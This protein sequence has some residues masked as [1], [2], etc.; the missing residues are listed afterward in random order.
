MDLSTN[1]GNNLIVYI[2]KTRFPNIFQ[3]NQIN[4]VNKMLSSPIDKCEQQNRLTLACASTNWFSM[5]FFLQQKIRRS[6]IVCPIRSY[7][8][9]CQKIR[10]IIRWISEPITAT[11]S[12]MR[13]PNIWFVNIS[14]IINRLIA[15]HYPLSIFKYRGI[16]QALKVDL[17][18]PNVR[19]CCTQLISNYCEDD[20]SEDRNESQFNGDGRM[21]FIFLISN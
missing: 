3:S 17:F 12:A 7:N 6:S 21:V 8:H 14:S 18:S 15:H 2:L 11:T 13:W 5:T 19:H 4:H 1:R 9:M 20:F 16:C 10:S